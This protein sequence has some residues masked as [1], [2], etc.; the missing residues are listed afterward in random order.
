VVVSE[1]AAGTVLAGAGDAE[2]LARVIWHDLECGG[3]RADLPLWRELAVR[4]G[5]PVLDIGAGSGRVALDL[6]R[7][8]HRVTA[9]D[10]DAALLG[11]LAQRGA[12]LAVET[13]HAD[14][15]SFALERRD[16]ALCLAPMQTIHLLGGPDGRLAFLRRAREHVRP[17][18]VIACA[19]LGELEPF[20]C[21]AGGDGPAAERAHVGGRL[22]LSRATRVSE[23]PG[24][25][26]IERERRVLR[27][28]PPPPRPAHGGESEAPPPER[29]IVVLD[30][31]S[32]ATLEHEAAAAGLRVLPRGEVPTTSD[33]VGSV[34]V[35]LG[36]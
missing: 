10:L 27:D 19:I 23:L 12:G 35:M 13:A 1:S 8:G 25:V 4:C 32:A 7:S 36:V 11:A 18:G 20:D 17:G 14:A 26:V 6:A 21:S 5:D 30:R 9:L 28:D 2:A 16:F 33:Y 31:L 15:R 29:D 22:Y 24:E 3:Y 34:V